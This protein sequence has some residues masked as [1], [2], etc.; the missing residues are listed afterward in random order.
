MVIK[1]YG[2]LPSGHS[3]SLNLKHYQPFFY[4][5]IPEDWKRAQVNTFT[6]Y[7]KKKVFQGYKKT[8][9]KTQIVI[10]KPFSEFTGTD[11]F[12]YIKLIFTNKEGFDA[13][14]KLFMFPLKIPE[15]N[16]GLSYKYDLFESNIEPILKFLHITGINPSGWVQIP[17][18]KYELVEEER[19]TLTHYEVDLEWDQIKSW[20]CLDA[21]PVNVAAFDIEADSSHGDFPMGIKGYEKLAQDLITFFNEFGLDIKKR[22]KHP[23]MR[24]SAQQVME[25]MLSLVFD[26]NYN[27]NGIHHIVTQNNLKP[28]QETIS[29]LSHAAYQLFQQLWDADIC[30]EDALDILTDQFEANLPAIDLGA[31]DSSYY[32]LLAREVIG[33]MTVL[34]KKNNKRF[35]EFP[36][37]VISS[38]I[39]LAFNDYYDG[40]NINCIY[41]KY[42][43]KPDF[44][45]IEAIVPDILKILT[46]CSYFANLKQLPSPPEITTADGTIY[47]KDNMCQ[48]AFVKQLTTLLNQ[49]LPPVEGDRLIQIGTTCQIQGQPDCYL[50]HIICLEE[51]NDITNEEMIMA[52]NQDIYLPAEDL[53]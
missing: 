15:L 24:Q 28:H 17:K 48:D 40:F 2:T 27:N 31:K 41:T 36:I 35:L 33:Q 37:E 1:A 12:Q 8:L 39:N 42:N 21:A 14:A 25:T 5:K 30:N 50:K 4:A 46:D 9:L 26:D 49:Y 10:R 16:G 20:E 52:E 45:I 34:K 51:T 47:N 44:N 19:T 6:N 38:L 18:R 53:A 7:L 32:Q 43:I 13:Y 22:K 23:F 29:Q 3:I 11:K